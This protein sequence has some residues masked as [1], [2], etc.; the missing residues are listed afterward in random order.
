M[1]LLGCGAEV[2]VD[3]VEVYRRGVP[4]RPRGLNEKVINHRRAGDRVRK[5]EAPAACRGQNGFRHAG[6]EL[7][8]DHGVEGVAPLLEDLRRRRGGHWVTAGDGPQAGLG[9]DARSL[10]LGRQSRM[11]LGR[12]G[13]P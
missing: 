13:G 12:V 10:G 11:A 1:E 8:G 9:R 5:E 3:R 2:G 7:G 6:G 4:G